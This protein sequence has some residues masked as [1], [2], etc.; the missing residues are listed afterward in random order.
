MDGLF[1]LGILDDITKN[2]FP[3][4]AG[5]ASVDQ[6]VHILAFEQA[7]KKLEA[8]PAFLDGLQ[9]EPFRNDRQMGK[10]P[11]AALDLDAF[12]QAKLQQMADGGRQDKALAL[13]MV[14]HFGEPPESFG[15][16]G[17][18]RRLFRDD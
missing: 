3:F 17:R 9:I 5:V 15:N 6:A 13:E 7:Q 16:V 11:L 18:H 4:A 1:G 12:R 8:V 10:C 2:Q 14:L